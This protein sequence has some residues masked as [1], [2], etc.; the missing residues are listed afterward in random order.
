MASTKAGSQGCFTPEPR[1]D[2]GIDL[3]E[4]RDK[5]SLPGFLAVMSHDL[6]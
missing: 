3:G 5:G 6:T 4:Q 2:P 1:C